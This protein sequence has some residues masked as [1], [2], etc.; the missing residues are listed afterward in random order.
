MSAQALTGRV[1]LFPGA[2]L[3]TIHS[4]RPDLLPRLAPGRRADDMPALLGSVFTLCASAHRLAA[5]AALHAARGLPAPDPQL[6]TQT[7]RLGTARDQILRISH[8]WPCHLLSGRHDDGATARLLRTCPLWREDLLPADRLAALPGWLAHKWLGHDPADWLARHDADPAG[9]PARWAAA[10]ST[11][12]GRLLDDLGPLARTL[13][14]P[15][16]TLHPQAA[17]WPGLARLAAEPGFCARPHWF[18]LPADTGPWSRRCAPVEAAATAWTRLIARV[19]E[20]LRLGQPDGADWLDHGALGLGP[21]EGLAWC[22]MARGLLVHRVALAPDGV[23]VRDWQV[24]APTE[25]NFH[26][27]GTLAR[28]LGTLSGHDRARQSA[29]ARLLAVAFDPCVEFDIIDSRKE[30]EVAHA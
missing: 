17:D 2:A 22:E 23:T 30:Q 8:D 21:G 19:T 15:G 5:T 4:S 20:V 13:A 27:E 7:L 18:G 26:P 25:W 16:L 28:A 1:R 10:S 12:L 9:W 11:P 3:P 29:A 24:L 6:A 14:T